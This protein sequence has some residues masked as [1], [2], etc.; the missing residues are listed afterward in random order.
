MTPTPGQGVQLHDI[1][2]VLAERL[3]DPVLRDLFPDI[4]PEAVRA[5]LRG[6]GPEAAPRDRG[7]QPPASVPT[8]KGAEQEIILSTDGA[9]RGNPGEAG[10]GYSIVNAQGMEI[11]AGSTYLGRCT[12]NEAEYQALILGLREAE[13]MRPTSLTVLLDS[14]L[15]VRQIQGRYKVKNE[16][17]QPLHAE[18]MRLLG[19]FRR[20]VIR[21]VRRE[22]NQRADELANRA[23]DE[24]K[25]PSNR[26][27]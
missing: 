15:C 17:L 27:L 7:H 6:R 20:P 19:L 2:A 1:L 14:E 4:S 12:N 23:I 10:A 13:G 16:R 11:F 8:T 21:H 18:V 5:L 22:A 3:P 24:R 9:S 25:N 26:L